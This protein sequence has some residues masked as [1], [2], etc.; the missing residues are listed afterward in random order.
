[1]RST[2]VKLC[3]IQLTQVGADTGV[4]LDIDGNQQSGGFEN[5]NM[6][7]NVDASS[8][9]PNNFALSS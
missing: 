7:S 8:L 1:M 5:F 2:C 4:R 6:L 9:K 3:L